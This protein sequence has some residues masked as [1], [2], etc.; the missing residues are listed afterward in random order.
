VTLASNRLGGNTILDLLNAQ[1]T[2]RSTRN[3]YNTAL[4]AYR[5][6]IAQLERA[7]GASLVR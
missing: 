3:D 7:I 1:A 4:A 6:A 2:V 5:Q